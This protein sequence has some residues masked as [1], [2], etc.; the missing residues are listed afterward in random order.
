MNDPVSLLLASL[1]AGRLLLHRQALI[2]ANPVC[3]CQSSTQIQTG[4]HPAIM[5]CFHAVF[6]FLLFQTLNQTL[7]TF[8]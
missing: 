6:L 7:I 1:A 5:K 8:V 4:T 3:L 2:S